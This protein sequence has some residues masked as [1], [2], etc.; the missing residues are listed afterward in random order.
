MT[1]SA[2]PPLPENGS[3]LT[4]ALG[5]V[6]LTMAGVCVV[7]L[8]AR[9]LWGL[10]SITFEP[11]NFFG[12]L[13]IQS[14][15]AFVLVASFA[16]I[17]ALRGGRANPRLDA[18]RAA[19]L[20]CTVTA[21][22]VFAIIVQQ[23]SLRAIRIDVPWSDVV[24]HYI[25]PAIALLEWA[26]SPRAHRSSW[27]VLAVVV[28]YTL[29]WGGLTMLR[30]ALTG[31]YPYYFLDPNQSND[32]GEFVLFAGAALVA[33]AAIGS[34]VVGLSVASAA[35][36]RSR[37]GGEAALGGLENRLVIELGEGESGLPAHNPKQNVVA[38]DRRKV[39]P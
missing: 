17:A 37:E 21:G 19:V 23:S 8:V 39:D 22:V 9:Y 29:C 30:G 31:W 26:V 18:V 25:L 4:R 5:F 6:R 36:W 13:T 15:M 16:G 24:L 12:Y 2:R 14:N 3:T 35:Y 34:A 32:L 38:R 10:G 28:G 11:G 33:F 1:V 7:S 20:T 27:R